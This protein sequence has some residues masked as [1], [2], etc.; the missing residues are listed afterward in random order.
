MITQLQL[1]LLMVDTTPFLVTIKELDELIYSLHKIIV[2]KIKV[3]IVVHNT[4]AVVL[5]S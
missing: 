4:Y 3:L 5:N 1:S 2:C